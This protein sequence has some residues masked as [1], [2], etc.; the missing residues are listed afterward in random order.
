MLRR[1]NSRSLASCKTL[2]ASWQIPVGTTTRSRV[3]SL[4]FKRTSLPPGWLDL[5]IGEAKTVLA[6]LTESVDLKEAAQAAA[7]MSTSDL[8]YQPPDGSQSLVKQLSLLHGDSGHVVVTNGAKHG[9]TAAL[10]TAKNAGCNRVGVLNPTWP[11]LL[12]TISLLG[13][14]HVFCEP[15][16][17]DAFDCYLLVSPN[18]PDGRALSQGE[19]TRLGEKLGIAGKFFVHDAAYYSRT[20]VD[21]PYG[22]FGNVQIHSA[23]KML[24]L[25]GLR[26]GW[27]VCADEETSLKMQEAVEATTAGVNSVTQGIVAN[28]LDVFF[29]NPSAR[30]DF[31]ERSS[32]YLERSR[33]EAQEVDPSF[34]YVDPTSP[35][36]FGAF[37]WLRKGPKYDP[38]AVQTIVVDGESYEKPD[39]FRVN[40]LA[41]AS[42]VREFVRRTRST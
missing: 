11:P 4:F 40:L 7:S 8:V 10:V 41:G 39:Y 35:D 6:A 33:R 15:D 17:L 37:A 1:F 21:G 36:N 9:V 38:E 29:K 25:A 34:G 32:Y 27:A 2:R 22:F 42:D 23:A 28:V 20:Y 3:S 30:I 24:G 5:G 14:Q 31:E 12:Q 13:M 18:N 19:L 16:D 26:V